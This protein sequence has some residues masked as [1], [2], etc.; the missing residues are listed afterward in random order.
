MSKKVCNIEFE[1]DEE[2]V[3][4][5]KKECRE[6]SNEKPC[7]DMLAYFFKEEIQESIKGV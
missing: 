6:D 2:W 4:E 5:I 1:I 7:L 3:E